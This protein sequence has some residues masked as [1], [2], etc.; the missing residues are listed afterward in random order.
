MIIPA[1][2]RLG[3]THDNEPIGYQVLTPNRDVFAPWTAAA[4]TA[5]GWWAAGGVQVPDA[6]GFIAWG[7]E[8]Q[9]AIAEEAIPPTPDWAGPMAQINRAN[10]A[11]LERIRQLLPP[12]PPVVV[13][14]A[15]F[16]QA[17]AQIQSDAHAAHD[18]YNQRIVVVAEALNDLQGIV[19]SLT[20]LNDGANQIIALAEM[21]RR[22][23]GILGEPTPGLRAVTEMSVSPLVTAIDALR[24]DMG[25]FTERVS[26]GKEVEA[27]RQRLVG[28]VDKLLGKLEEQPSQ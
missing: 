21:Q 9:P 5:P 14:T 16:D 19:S 27:K 17:V 13:D 12:P 3:R 1:N 10:A 7:L 4:R 6:G 11:L 25:A 2:A 24:A 20:I 26:E 15:R 8:G 18:S 28:A 22:L 23:N